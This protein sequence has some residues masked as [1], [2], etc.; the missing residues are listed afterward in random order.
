MCAY[1]FFFFL[2]GTVMSLRSVYN[3]LAAYVHECL[4]VVSSCIIAQEW[5]DGMVAKKSIR[6]KNITPS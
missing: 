3:N 5:A 6:T 4:G 1:F 2:L